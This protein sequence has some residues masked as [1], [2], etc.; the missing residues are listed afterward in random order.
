MQP[1]VNVR[2]SVCLSVCVL[3]GK[4]LCVYIMVRRKFGTGA[5]CYRL[6][7]FT[8]WSLYFGGFHHKA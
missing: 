2:L 6:S 5:I 3:V 1:P 4:H 8:G 7:L